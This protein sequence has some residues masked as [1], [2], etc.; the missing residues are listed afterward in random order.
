MRSVEVH[1]PKVVATSAKAG[2][3]SS[4]ARLTPEGEFLELPEFD[5]ERLLVACQDAVFEL[6]LAATMSTWCPR[7]IRKSSRTRGLGTPNGH[8]FAKRAMSGK[9][10][11]EQFEFPLL[12][13]SVPTER[14]G[15]RLGSGM[16]PNER[17][18]FPLGSGEAPTERLVLTVGSGRAS[19]EVGG[20]R[21]PQVRA[22]AQVLAYPKS[23]ALM[24]TQVFASAESNG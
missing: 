3:N 6:Y 7:S 13:G 23:A 20:W 21:A 18:A 1:R 4:A 5:I 15:F 17:F 16:V 14:F 10:P 9:L 24:P 12:S 2:K 8:R 22:K 11:T 19:G